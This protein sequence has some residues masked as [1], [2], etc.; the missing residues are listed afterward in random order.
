MGCASSGEA[1]PEPPSLPWAPPPEQ[2]LRAR[3]A[4]DGVVARPL[5]AALEAALPDVSRGRRWCRLFSLR[6]HG[7]SLGTLLR[8]TRGVAPTLL[9]VRV[10]DARVVGGFVS[11]PWV[12]RDA[13]LGAHASADTRG[14]FGFG[15]SAFVWAAGASAAAALEGVFPVVPGLPPQYLRVAA[16][17]AGGAVALELGVGGG[18]GAFALLLDELLETCTS[19]ACAAFASPPLCAERARVLDVEV[20]GWAEADDELPAPTAH[21]AHAG[22]GAARG[23][24]DAALRR[25]ADVDFVRDEPTCPRGGCE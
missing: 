4:F 13:P 6:A 23:G 9:A 21:H 18:G 5:A 20:W 24:P 7:A 12:E 2:P 3:D 11:E 10:A 16:A 17:R 19:G 1:W 8:R 15:R 22:L 14:F 25:G